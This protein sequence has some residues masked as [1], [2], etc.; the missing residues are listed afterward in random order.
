M[1]ACSFACHRHTLIHTHSTS[2]LLKEPKLEMVWC[3][4]ELNAGY[5][6][7]GYARKRGIGCAVVTFC[8]GGWVVP[9]AWVHVINV[10]C[11]SSKHNALPPLHTPPPHPFLS[12]CAHLPSHPPPP[13]PDPHLRISRLSSPCSFSILNAI[14]GAYSEDLPGRHRQAR[15]AGGGATAS[16][17]GEEPQTVSIVAHSSY[18]LPCPAPCHQAA[19]AVHAVAGWGRQQAIRPPTCCASPLPLQ[20]SS[21]RVGPTHPPSGLLCAVLCFAQSSSSRVGPTQTTL[22]PSTTGIRGRVVQ[23]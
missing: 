3:C 15:P 19:I 5:A 17:G 10:V 11:L 8:V 6:A 9:G 16:I 1:L 20:S 22:R 13:P 14:G 2:Q 21:S 7:D 23:A 18:A 12:T 4:N